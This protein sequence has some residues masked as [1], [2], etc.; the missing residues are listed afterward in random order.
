MVPI[1][2]IISLK[3]KFDLCLVYWSIRK[4]VNILR[5]SY[6]PRVSLVLV[7]YS[8]ARI[9]LIYYKICWVPFI[10]ALSCSLCRFIFFFFFPSCCYYSFWNTRIC[11]LVVSTVHTH[12]ARG[13]FSIQSHTTPLVFYINLLVIYKLSCPVLYFPRLRSLWERI[14]QYVAFICICTCTYIL[15]SLI[16]DFKSQS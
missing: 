4:D 15:V 7:Q 9:K 6:W 1:V 10:I 2:M 14:D 12:D 8:N 13:L 5:V 16:Y 3:V 11:G